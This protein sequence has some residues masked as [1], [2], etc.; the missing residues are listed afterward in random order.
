M[1]IIK[2]RKCHWK[3]KR[4]AKLLK[5]FLC[6]YIRRLSIIKKGIVSKFIYRLKQSLSKSR[7]H[8]FQKWIR[9]RWNLCGNEKSIV[10]Q[11]NL[12]KEKQRWKTHMPCL[13]KF[14]QGDKKNFM[15]YCPMTEGT[16]Q[17]NTIRNPG[18]SPH[19]WTGFSK[20]TDSNQLVRKSLSIDDI[21]WLYVNN[22]H[23]CKCTTS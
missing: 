23:K 14:K 5:T 4:R 13:Q 16:S 7:L 21:R 19:Y 9:V 11:N 6:L 10:G 18:T 20:S 12:D 8:I 2:T 22:L 15:L 1:F 17:Q 3:A